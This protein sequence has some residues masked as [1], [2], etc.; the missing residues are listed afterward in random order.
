MATLTPQAIVGQLVNERA[1]RAKVFERFGIDYCCGGKLSIA[2]ACGKKGVD[3]TA[4]LAALDAV[5]AALGTVT[6]ERDWTQAPIDTLITHILDT[7]HAYL[8][9]ALP[10]LGFLVEKVARVH[11]E[12]HPE[13]TEVAATYRRFHED[14]VA[15]MAKEETVLFPLTRALIQAH[16]AGCT[17]PLQAPLQVMEAEHE[18]AGRDLEALNT[19]TGGYVPPEGA[20]NSYRAMLDGLRELEQD[21]HRHVHLENNVLFPRVRAML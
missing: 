19:L 3:P 21:T 6:D 9:D 10:R 18:Q 17:P 11:G 2:D 20:C 5:D 8:R 7:H 14:M 16:E 12:G 13:L 4:V 15:H 1:S